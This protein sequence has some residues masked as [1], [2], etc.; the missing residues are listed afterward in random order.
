[1][2]DINYNYDTPEIK[3]NIYF[4]SNNSRQILDKQK[5]ITLSYSCLL[6]LSA[7]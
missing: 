5:Q 7:Q 6:I 4:M 2:F 1:M 3:K